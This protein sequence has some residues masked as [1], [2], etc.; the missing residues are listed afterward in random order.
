MLVRLWGN[1]FAFGFTV[2]AGGNRFAEL[3]ETVW[4]SY[5]S[6]GRNFSNTTDNQ[7]THCVY[8]EGPSPFAQGNQVMNTQFCLEG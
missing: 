6:F 4:Y 7:A 5:W 2:R 1:V 8:T 3:P